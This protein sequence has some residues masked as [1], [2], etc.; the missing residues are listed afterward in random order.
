[1]AN[2]SEV[3][4]EEAAL[5]QLLTN[6]FSATDGYFEDSDVT[7]VR[8]NGLIGRTELR[9]INLP[10]CT[11]IKDA[12]FNG[13]SNL[14]SAVLNKV[15]RIDKNA[16][17]NTKLSVVNE[18][19]FQSLTYVNHG[20]FGGT[21]L[22]EFIAPKVTYVGSNA[23]GNVTTLLKIIIPIG[24]MRTACSGATALRFVDM[25]TGWLDDAGTKKSI[26]TVTFNKC[27][28]LTTL[29]LRNSTIV[30]LANVDAF[31]DTKYATNGAGGAYVYVPRDLIS[32]YQAATNWATLYAA[33]PDMFRALEDYTVD[34]TTTGEFDESLISA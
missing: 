30:G 1:M 17:N 10:N 31:T 16:F 18:T 15:S 14:T 9:S 11:H 32:S 8:A 4:G 34:G 13:C 2:N 7:I 12:G 27:A 3:L 19:N 23:F 25:L 29:V 21:K 26:A 6:D 33:H 5:R 24:G 22:T 28:S 20:V